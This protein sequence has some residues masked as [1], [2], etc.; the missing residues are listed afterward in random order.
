M[1]ETVAI[2]T[3]A[4]IVEARRRMRDL[5]EPLQLSAGDLAMVATAVS[6]LARNI[7]VY[8]GEGRIE[9]GLIEG[10]R[11][12]GVLVIASDSGPGIQDVELAL[13]DGFSTSNSLG[14]GLPGSRR[15][16]DEF[17]LSSK[18]GVGTTVTLRKWAPAT[19]P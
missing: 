7:L 9:L 15:L 14:L 5:A 11:K 18:V 12:R 3:D 8:A 17:E 4:D 1:T 19:R 13:Q 6:E 2:R 10:E 16:V